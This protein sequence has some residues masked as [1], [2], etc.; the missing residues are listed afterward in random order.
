MILAV[1]ILL[2]G[3]LTAPPSGDGDP[4]DDTDGEGLPGG[5]EEGDPAPA[6][7]PDCTTPLDL[8][9]VSHMLAPAGDPPADPATASF[10]G[11]ALFVNPG[12]QV[13]DLSGATVSLRG[14]NTTG[15]LA[16][17]AMERS[18]I[19]LPGG[20]AHGRLPPDADDLVL[21]LVPELWSSTEAPGIS[22]DL[23]HTLAPGASFAADFDVRVGPLL[24]PMRV[25]VD[26]VA[27]DPE[28]RPDAWTFWASDRVHAICDSVLLPD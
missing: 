10:E 9:F 27:P 15:P 12:D 1:V 7:A 13:L 26:V 14:V 2:T 20:E 21:G 6:V 19:G 18:T 11:F 28:G 3:C 25:T 5:E 8:A 24:F 4:L 16:A 22:V 17:I 23:Q